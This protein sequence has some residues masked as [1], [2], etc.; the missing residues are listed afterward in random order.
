MPIPSPAVAAAFGR[1]SFVN[2]DPDGLALKACPTRM[3]ASDGLGVAIGL[4]LIQTTAP[5]ASPSWW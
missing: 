4:G 2:K 5:A 1:N 3:L